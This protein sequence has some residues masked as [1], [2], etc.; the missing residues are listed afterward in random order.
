L[1]RK[2]NGK[3]KEKNHEENIKFI[4]TGWIPDL[5]HRSQFGISRHQQFYGASRRIKCRLCCACGATLGQALAHPLCDAQ[6]MAGQTA[7]SSHLQDNHL[8]KWQDFQHH[9]PTLSNPLS[10]R[11]FLP[12]RKPGEKE[13]G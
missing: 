10:D 6:H 12:G 8:S 9:R 7:L 1:P 11:R 4:V 2:T 13:K 5:W 3:N